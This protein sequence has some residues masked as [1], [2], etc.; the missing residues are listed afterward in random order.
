MKTVYSGDA[1][2]KKLAGRHTIHPDKTYKM[3]CFAYPFTHRGRRYLFNTVT[4]ECVRLEEGE[5]PET[6]GFSVSGAEAAQSGVLSQLAERF[7]LAPCDRD[8]DAFYLNLFRLSRRMTLKKG[9]ILYTI[10]PTTACNARC[11]YCYESGIKYETMNDATAKQTVR[12]I[13]DT[14]RPGKKIQINWFGG[15]PLVGEAVIDEITRGLNEAGLD[16]RSMIITNGSLITPE[17]VDKMKK[18]W[19]LTSAQVSMD[20]NEAD[21]NYRK[22]YVHSYESAY[23]VVLQNVKLLADSGIRTDLRCN[24]DNDNIDGVKTLADDIKA[25]APDKKY[26]SFYLTLLFDV[27]KSEAGL[28]VWQKSFEVSRYIESLGYSVVYRSNPLEMKRRSCM[29]D[30]PVEC[31]VIAPDGRTFNC[32][33]IM[34]FDPTGNVF[35]GV[36]NDALVRSFDEAEPVR[37]KCSGCLYLPECTTFSRCGHIAANCKYY[38]GKRLDIMVRMLVDRKDDISAPEQGGC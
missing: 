16:Y 13:L 1:L 6:D 25:L 38:R 3:S 36:T 7:F 30:D 35:D 8:E 28:E 5:L 33:N 29:A 17:L 11:I 20:G 27:L 12:F 19:R 37:E 9:Y 21:Y 2:I 14:C 18:D 22:C 26:I 23:R 34:A 32:E 31:T 10:L 15:E 24:V 4:R